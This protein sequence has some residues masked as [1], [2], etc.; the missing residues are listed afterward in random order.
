[1][2]AYLRLVRKLEYPNSKYLFWNHVFLQ[3][4]FQAPNN[5]KYRKQYLSFFAY[6]SPIQNLQFLS[7]HSKVVNFKV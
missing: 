5:L 4:L 3:V 1:M 2:G 6:V 7:S